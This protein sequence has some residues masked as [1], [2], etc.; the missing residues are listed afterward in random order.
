MTQDMQWQH[1]Q[2]YPCRHICG[3][4]SHMQPRC[5]FL[6][7]S[8][9][10]SYVKFCRWLIAKILEINSVLGISDVLEMVFGSSKTLV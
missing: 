7:I 2:I 3:K 10:V 4:L 9:S 8:G 1:C 5:E 6:K